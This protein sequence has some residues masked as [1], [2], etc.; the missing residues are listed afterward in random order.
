[1]DITEILTKLGCQKEVLMNPIQMSW[2][3][4]EASPNSM[5][6][7][8]GLIDSRVTTPPSS[9]PVFIGYSHH[10]NL[11]LI[12]ERQSSG[13]RLEEDMSG[14]HPNRSPSQWMRAWNPR[15]FLYYRLLLVIIGESDLDVK[16]LR[17]M[18]LDP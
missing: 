8:F 18:L 13:E 1:M 7:K 2:H 11:V 10:P 12:Y 17:P 14:S 5:W 16:R 3:R 15:L 4:I 9:L 6:L